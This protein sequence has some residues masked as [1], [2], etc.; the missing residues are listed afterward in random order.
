MTEWWKEIFNDNLYECHI[1]ASVLKFSAPKIAGEVCRVSLVRSRTFLSETSMLPKKL[2]QDVPWNPH[3]L[4]PQFLLE[5]FFIYLFPT[6][7]RKYRYKGQSLISGF[8]IKFTQIVSRKTMTFLVNETNLIR[9]DC[10]GINMKLCN[11]ICTVS[12][13]LYSHP[14]RSR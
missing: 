13:H 4:L 8:Q 6:G 11:L 10:E 9:N 3:F 14:L 1:S 12:F 2:E 5:S 7:F